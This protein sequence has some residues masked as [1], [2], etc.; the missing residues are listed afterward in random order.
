MPDFKFKVNLPQKEHKEIVIP[1]TEQVKHIIEESRGTKLYLPILFAALLGMRRSEVCALTWDNID[2]EKKTILIDEALVLDEY[3]SFVRK[4]TKTTN[5]KRVLDIPPRILEA[6]PPKGARIIR[7]TPKS[8]TTQF[9][10]L[11]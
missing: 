11:V 8:L 4:K 1:T 3:N 5:S 10:T 6:L 7:L 9:G 2:L